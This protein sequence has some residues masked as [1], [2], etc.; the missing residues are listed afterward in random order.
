MAQEAVAE[1]IVII[2]LMIILYPLKLIQFRLA[3]KEQQILKVAVQ[4]SIQLLVLA[5]VKAEAPVLAVPAD[6]EAEEQL[7]HPVM[8][9]VPEILQALHHHKEILVPVVGLAVVLIPL[10]E[11]EEL[12]PQEAVQV[13]VQ[14]LKMIF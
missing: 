1:A 6:L 12:H 5:A 4:L 14:D 3:L 10:E 8:L 9:V 11:A 7:I 2:L 13:E